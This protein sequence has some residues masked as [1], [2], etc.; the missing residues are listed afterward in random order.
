VQARAARNG[1]IFHATGGVQWVRDLG[2][3]LTGPHLMDIPW[4]YG[5]RQR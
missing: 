2:L 1:K 5:Y 4:L 3:R